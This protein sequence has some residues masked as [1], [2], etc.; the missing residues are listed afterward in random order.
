[1]RKSEDMKPP[2][3]MLV[4]FRWYCH[5]DFREEIEGDLL[6][7]F[8]K[9]IEQ[10]GL[11]KAK[12]LFAKE[13]LLLFRPTV[14]KNAGH[15][16][17]NYF[18]DMKTFISILLLSILLTAL[19]A[20]PFFPG[21]SNGLVLGLSSLSLLFGFFG[22]LLVPVGIIWVIAGWIKNKQRE[23]RPV[24][25]KPSYYLSIIAAVIAAIIGV[26]FL[27]VFGQHA[28]VPAAVI[29][30][31]IEGWLLYKV[32]LSIRKIKS[33]PSRAFNSVPVYLI[34]LPLVAFTAN[35]FL[36]EPISTYSR[37]TAIHKSEMLIAAI[38]NYNI[39][40]GKYP[41]S[42]NELKGKYIDKI[43]KPSV[44][45]VAN[46]RYTKVNNHYTLS[47][48][49]WKDGTALEELVIY[50]KNPGLYNDYAHFDYKID[51]Y[52]IKGAFESHNTG[53]KNWR[54]YLCD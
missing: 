32:V 54:Y 16:T 37:N 3:V 4:F 23:D 49:Q 13:V 21:P 50:D 11:T 34:V 28:G 18:S 15:L 40:E 30:L 42:L 12:K 44:M 26:I 6:E 8:N 20:S 38:E 48:S 36:V 29:A 47:F 43:P 22:L 33:T 1:M 19:I 14:I 41:A 53:I 7:Q 51:R 31:V 17:F 5:P 45:G 46:Y 39:K 35:K 2:K 25:W 52:R 10:Y 27:P 9:R 24:N